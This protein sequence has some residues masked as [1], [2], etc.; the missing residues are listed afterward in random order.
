MPTIEELTRRIEELEREN[1][2]LRD[3]LFGVPDG[4]TFVVPEPLRPVFEQ[5]QQTVSDYFRRVRVNPTR[6]FIE[7]GD[8]RYVLVRASGLSIDFLD[9]ILGLY[10]DR[11]EEEA[12]AIGKGILFDI[13]HSIGISDARKF[14]E[15]MSLT[16]PIARFSAGPIHFAHSGWAL[17]E[18]KPSS[19][20]VPS[21]EFFLC[22][23]HP[24][25]FE[26]ASW[27]SAGRRSTYPVCVMSAG[28]SS[29]W[30]EESFGLEL[31]AVEVSCQARGDATCTFV[32]APPGRIALQLERH[33]GLKPEDT[34]AAGVDIPT[35]FDR[36]RREE[37]RER[38]IE[39][40]KTALGRIKTLRGLVPIC[41]A[42]KKV[43]DD[44]GYWH[45][46]EEYLARHSEAEFSH[47]LCPECRSNLYGEKPK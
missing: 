37:E 5:A 25:S 11:D 47:G 16:D 39:E 40:L 46:V 13:A 12:L 36:K 19:N 24:Y 26:A 35:Y 7:I 2:E 32:M 28:Y 41:S 9:T 4:P 23:D 10:A 27:L 44:R 31:T 14:H 6:G 38:L 29:G 17:V 34:G 45:Q 20:P 43:R 22:Y 42:C 8:E 3:G 30:C 21:E 33:F 1:R 18:I 15:R